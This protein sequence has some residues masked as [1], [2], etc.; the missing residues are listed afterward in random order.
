MLFSTINTAYSQ[1]IGFVADS[2]THHILL[3]DSL[4]SQVV[5]ALRG[6]ERRHEEI[7]KKVRVT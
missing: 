3:A 5:E 7:K 2:A 1:I 6:V 4:N